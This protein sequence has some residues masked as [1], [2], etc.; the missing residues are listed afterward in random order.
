M[1]GGADA[2]QAD[3]QHLDDFRACIRGW[4]EKELVWKIA[5]TR[6]HCYKNGFA[7]EKVILGFKFFSTTCL[8]ERSHPL[9]YKKIPSDPKRRCAVFA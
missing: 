3:T 8:S 1:E 9:K 4:I 5:T 7:F 6:M 2:G